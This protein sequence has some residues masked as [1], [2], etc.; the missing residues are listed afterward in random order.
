M[1]DSEVK[2]D[3]VPGS[4]IARAQLIIDKQQYVHNPKINAFLLQGTSQ[5]H[6]VK[7]HPHTHTP[8]TR[9]HAHTHTHTHTH[10]H[11]RAHTPYRIPINVHTCAYK[12]D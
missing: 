10:T 1:D 12:P 6:A 8:H 5:V 7:I 11:A 3:T 2:T 4:H 9:T